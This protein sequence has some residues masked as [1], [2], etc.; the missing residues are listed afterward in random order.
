MKRIA[1]MLIMTAMLLTGCD[2]K[3]L[4]LDEALELEP[5]KL[6]KAV[7]GLTYDE[8]CEVWGSPETE[9][10]NINGSAFSL[11]NEAVITYEDP[12]GYVDGTRKCFWCEG[13]FAAGLNE[14]NL[15]L[16][17]KDGYIEPVV[18]STAK[19]VS[20]DGIA[21]GDKVRILVETIAESY[22]CQ[23]EA[24]G[25]K[26]IEKGSYDDLDIEIMDSLREMGWVE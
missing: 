2:K 17:E 26:L 19:F 11:G 15:V 21:D 4:P 14:N 5:D 9:S 23:T 1:A 3:P 13:R 20:F 16:I 6:D 12:K 18:V 10:D 24:Y 7:I 8:L 22:P 25:V